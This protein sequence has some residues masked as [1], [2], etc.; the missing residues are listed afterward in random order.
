MSEYR[1]RTGSTH[2]DGT[3][4]FATVGDTRNEDEVA[5]ILSAEWK[6]EVNRFGMLAPVD[7]YSTRHGRL[8]GILE[9]K[10]R[11]HD[12]G[13]FPTVFLNVRKWLAL[14]LASQGLGVPAIFVVRFTDTLCWCPVQEINPGINKIGGCGARMKSS[15]DVEPVIEVPVGLLRP[16]GARKR[17]A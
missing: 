12:Y 11:A 6:C 15:S 1:D 5:S 16:V 10:S 7:W 17:L 14:V 3:P 8:V 9:L 2:L 13:K 4:I